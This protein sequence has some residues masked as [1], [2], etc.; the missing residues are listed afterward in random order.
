MRRSTLILALFVGAASLPACSSD[1]SG[2]DGGSGGGMG[3]TG[4]TVGGTGQPAE[5][6]VD[7]F[8]I[9]M[10]GAFIPNAA[11]RPEDSPAKVAV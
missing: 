5:V 8:N 7:T 3:G 1:D 10:A 2:G 9:A 6:T 11:E 4:G